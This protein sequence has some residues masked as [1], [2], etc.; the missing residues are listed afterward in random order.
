[1]ETYDDRLVTVDYSP[2]P[3][4]LGKTVMLRCCTNGIATRGGEVPDFSWQTYL[5]DPAIPG[6]AVGV[7]SHTLF[8]PNFTSEQVGLYR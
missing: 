1:M 2:S 3:D 4:E 5:N 7:N 6:N 8:L